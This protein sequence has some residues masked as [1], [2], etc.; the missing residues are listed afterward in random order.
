MP[1]YYTIYIG[2]QKIHKSNDK[3]IRKKKKKMASLISCLSILVTPLLVTS[4][5]YQVS[6]ANWALVESNCHYQVSNANWALVESNCHNSTEY[7]FCLSSLLSDKRS[8][9][10]TLPTL[11]LNSIELD[12]KVVEVAVNQILDL[13]KTL[14]THWKRLDFK[15]AKVILVM[16]TRICLV[17]VTVQVFKI[18]IKW[19]LHLRLHFWKLEN[20]VMNMRAP[21]NVNHHYQISLSK[22]G[23]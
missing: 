6:N 7:E 17:Q 21:Q 4:L 14:T 20:V 15:I 23:G 12:L 19:K 18:M 10:S 13:L 11:E 2:N 5:F 16:Y 8:I 22:W 3:E 9:K 1:T